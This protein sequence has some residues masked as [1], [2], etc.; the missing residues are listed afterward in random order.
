MTS[1]QSSAG[2]EPPR[3][4]AGPNVAQPKSWQERREERLKEQEAMAE[5]AEKAAKQQATQGIPDEE[6]RDKI[7]ALGGDATRSSP[8]LSQALPDP[9]PGLTTTTGAYRVPIDPTTAAVAAGESDPITTRMRGTPTV[10]SGKSGAKEE[11]WK[12]PEV[13]PK[14]PPK[15]AK[16]AS[17]K[18]SQ[19]P[20]QPPRR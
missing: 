16:S 2:N 11:L 4:S 1:T 13:D 18:P 7:L 9:E 15:E 5:A 3:A 8:A 14:N 17:S 19:P 10:G 12:E 6:T 20:S